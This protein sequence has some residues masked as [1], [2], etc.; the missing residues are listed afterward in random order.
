MKRAI[1][2]PS[3]PVSLAFANHMNRFVTGD[4]AKLPRR[5]ENAGLH[6]PRR[7]VAGDP[8]PGRY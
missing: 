1:A 7:L 4:R 6:E 5:S 3:D 8:V 2:R